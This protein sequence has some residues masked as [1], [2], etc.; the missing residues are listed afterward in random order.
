MLQTVRVQKVNEKNRV[1]CLVSMFPR[2]VMVPKLSKKVYFLQ[3]CTD[4]SK[5]NTS[6]LKQFTYLHLKVVLT[7]FQ[8]M[9][10]FIGV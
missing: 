6:L 10:W 8:K 1:I 3:F 9:V 5:K 4:L 7:L 2:I